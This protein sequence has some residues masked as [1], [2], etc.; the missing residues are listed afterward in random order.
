MPLTRRLRS[1][2]RGVRT[3]RRLKAS[4][5]RVSPAARSA[6]C[7]IRATSPRASGESVGVLLQQGDVAQ[8]SGEEI[9]EVVG[10]AVRQLGEALGALQLPHPLLALP[11]VG[12][13]LGDADQPGEA[14]RRGGPRHRSVLDPAVL[15]VGTPQTVLRGVALPPGHRLTSRLSRGRA[16]LGVDRLGP[17][18]THLLVGG[19]AGEG[20]PMGVGVVGLTVRTGGPDHERERVVRGEDIGHG[21]NL[22]P[23]SGKEQGERW[24]RPRLPGSLWRMPFL[25]TERQRAAWLILAL[26][27]GTLWVLW[28]FG[29]GLLGALVLYVVFAPL[30][31]MLTRWM[32]PGAAAGMAV[33]LG[34]VLVLGPG[35][36]IVGLVANQAQDMATSVIRSPLLARLSQI[37]VGP[38]AVGRPARVGRLPARLLGGGERGRPDR[39][40]DPARHSA[41]HRLLRAVLPARLSAGGLAQRPAVHPVL[42]RERRG[43]SRALSR[44]HL[45]HPGRH[46]A[47]RRGAG[48]ARGPGVLGDRSV[49]S[50]RSGA[51]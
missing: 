41:H 29:T 25:D 23:R 27:L 50:A 28:P 32:R 47:H 16:V 9:V 18:P 42:R 30:H 44:R 24:R 14:S 43:A 21:D 13:V 36:S 51:W 8:D 10:D 31:R 4:S 37:R 2:A 19:P 48:A 35:I 15:A 38:Y 6:A 26:G 17:A 20:E 3:W 39:H 1:S 46:R 45:L 33:V 40:G 49:Q 22:A 12:D 7:S 11:S 34:L 5:W